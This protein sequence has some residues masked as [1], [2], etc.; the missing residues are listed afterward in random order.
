[1]TATSSRPP[2]WAWAALAVAVLA[3]SSGGL[4]F[5]LLTETPPVLKACWRLA[6]TCRR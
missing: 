1:M 5:A 2:L 6:L 4:W 3:M